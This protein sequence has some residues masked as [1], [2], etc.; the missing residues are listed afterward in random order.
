MMLNTYS[1]LLITAQSRYIRM[2]LI[3]ENKSCDEIFGCSV[4]MKAR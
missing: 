1:E 2:P 3:M 4:S